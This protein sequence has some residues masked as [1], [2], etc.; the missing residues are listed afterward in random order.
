T[1]E[2]VIE[3]IEE[4][5]QEPT[6]RADAPPGPEQSSSPPLPAEPAQS[7]Q[8]AKPSEAGNDASTPA[9]EAVAA[10]VPEEPKLDRRRTSQEPALF[11]LPVQEPRAKP[12]TARAE[13]KDW[14]ELM[15]RIISDRVPVKAEQLKDGSLRY[16]VPAL[17]EEERALLQAKRF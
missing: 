1:P 12:G 14:D 15:R 3:D 8:R 11:A 4:A 5:S 13:Y 7:D 2:T 6:E 10:P 17:N 16:S 9:E